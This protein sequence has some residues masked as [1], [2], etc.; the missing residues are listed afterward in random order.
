MSVTIESHK[1]ISTLKRGERLV[2]K[3]FKYADDMH[4]FLNTGDN[5]LRWRESSKG[6]KAGTYAFAGGKWHNVKRLDACML[7]HI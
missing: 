4:K 7:A 2:I 5:A 1:P 6:L 3:S